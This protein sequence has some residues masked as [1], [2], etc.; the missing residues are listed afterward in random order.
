MVTTQQQP[1]LQIV[2]IV[3]VAVQA[4]LPTTSLSTE[5]R[6]KLCAWCWYERQ[7]P[8]QDA[9]VGVAQAENLVPYPERWSSSICP[10]HER[11]VL[12]EARRLRAERRARK[13]AAQ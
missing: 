8:E 3:P 9:L 4:Q 12:D 10:R 2:D 13:E 7:V 6:E 1:S 5:D 11:Q